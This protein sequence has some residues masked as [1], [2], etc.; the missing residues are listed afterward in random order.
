MSSTSVR[1]RLVGGV[2]D[3][4]RRSGTS[5]RR[6]TRRAP[7]PAPGLRPRRPGAVPTTATGRAAATSTRA[8]PATRT[9][10][11]PTRMPLTGT[12]ETSTKPVRTVPT[13]A[14]TVPMPDR[15]PTTVPVSSRF[16]SSSLVTIGVTAE[17]SAPGTRIVSAA[18]NDS[19]SG[20]VSATVRTTAGVTATTTPDT[21]SS[22]AQQTPRVDP[23]GRP[24]AAPRAE[25]D[26]AERDADHQRAGLE[27]EAEVRREQPQ[28]GQLDHEHGRGRA[29]DQRRSRPVPQGGR[30]DRGA[31]V[32]SGSW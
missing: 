8:R 25:G 28:H 19:S 18:T 29:E 30:T 24:A 27:G 31:H 12:R 6:R 3:D 15:R 20:A 7:P 14:P 11:S 10:P 22:G 26:R 1:P 23:V 16:V 21:P 2:V 13:I 9:A 32:V 4:Q 17:S 5:S